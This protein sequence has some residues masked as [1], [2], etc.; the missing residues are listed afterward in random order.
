MSTRGRAIAPDHDTSQDRRPID[1][2]RCPRLETFS[3]PSAAL[4][5]TS[6]P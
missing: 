2:D 4:A 3:H 5:L 6:T 1:H